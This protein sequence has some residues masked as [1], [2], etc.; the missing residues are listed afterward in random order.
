MQRVPAPTPWT[1]RTAG[2]LVGVQGLAAAGVCAVLLVRT[3]R[4]EA[5]VDIA[6][7]VALWF[8]VVAAAVVAVGVALWR[9]RQGARSPGIV[10]EVLL[11][12]VAWYAAG[13]SSQP[14]YGILGGLYCLAALVLL[15]SAPTGRWMYG[16]DADGRISERPPAD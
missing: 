13:P 1:V 10:T 14:V 7:G 6:L 9:G 3:V 12:G 16:V 5:D 11:L 2:V 15:F 4:A 8:A